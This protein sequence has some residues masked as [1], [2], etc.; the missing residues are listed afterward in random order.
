MLL[1]HRKN[2][3]TSFPVNPH[4]PNL[5]GG[6]FTPQIL[7]VGVQKYFKTSVFHDPPPNLGGKFHPPHLGGTL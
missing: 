7:A 4:P 2:G 1:S 5:G 6:V 3:L